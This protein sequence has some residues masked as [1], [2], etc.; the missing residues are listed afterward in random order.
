M[1]KNNEEKK[2]VQ[3]STVIVIPIL[4]MLSIIVFNISQILQISHNES[5]RQFSNEVSIQ[6]SAREL[7]I[8]SNRPITLHVI[9]L[10]EKGGWITDGE[11]RAVLTNKHNEEITLNFYHVEDGLYETVTMIPNQGEWRGGIEVVWNNKYSTI[12]LQMEVLPN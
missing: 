1:E 4:I 8:T 9:A 7:P 2:L 6:W 12:P 10:D 3:S 11:A 5:P